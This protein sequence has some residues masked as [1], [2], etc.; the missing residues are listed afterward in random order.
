M[1][2]HPHRHVSPHIY[3]II[4]PHQVCACPYCTS[5]HI[6]E[7]YVV[8]RFPHISSLGYLHTKSIRLTF[9]VLPTRS[10]KMMSEYRRKRINIRSNLMNIKQRASIS[11]IMENILTLFYYLLMDNMKTRDSTYKL[12]I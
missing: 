7:P 6:Y 5:T 9:S 10:S 3:P 2:P 8:P 11:K 1:P 4:P 12:D